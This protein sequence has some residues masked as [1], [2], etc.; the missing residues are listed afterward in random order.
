MP[1]L[2]ML[3]LLRIKNCLQAIIT[4]M[5]NLREAQTK[6]EAEIYIEVIQK[7]RSERMPDS[8]K[9]NTLVLDDIRDGLGDF[10]KCQENCRKLGLI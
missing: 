10:A 7:I 1:E 8:W 3:D 9:L 4:A 2:N 5:T 6:E